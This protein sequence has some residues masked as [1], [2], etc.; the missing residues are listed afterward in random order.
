MRVDVMD[1]CI[2]EI[3]QTT[4]PQDPLKACLIGTPNSESP[5]IIECVNQL[6]ASPSIFNKRPFEEL[7]TSKRQLVPSIE[8]PPELEL[9]LTPIHLKY[10]F[11]G[12]SSTLPVIVSYSLSMEQ[13]E[14][15]LRL[16]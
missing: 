13:E 15:F 2:K 10:A 6:E 4:T 8:K 5:N 9:K 12:D 1:G 14:N 3:L 16:L 11:L 7:E